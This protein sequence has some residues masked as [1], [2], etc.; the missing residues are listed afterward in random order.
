MDSRTLTRLGTLRQLE[1]FLKVA[2]HKSMTRAAEELFLSHSAVSL[3]I[4]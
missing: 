2:E 4:R 1:I 3:Q